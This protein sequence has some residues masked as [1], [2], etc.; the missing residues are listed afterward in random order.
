MSRSSQS[1][2]AT[3]IC[4]CNFAGSNPSG[5]HIRQVGAV[6]GFRIQPMSA[7]LAPPSSQAWSTLWTS[8]NFAPSSPPFH[9]PTYSS[10]TPS[11]G[12]PGHL[13]AGLFDSRV[14][15]NML[16]AHENQKQAQ[17]ICFSTVWDLDC[18]PP[19]HNAIH[20]CHYKPHVSHCSF[21]KFAGVVL[22]HFSDFPNTQNCLG[23]SPYA[24]LRLLNLSW[25]S[26]R[27]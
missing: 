16:Y 11:S 13:C 9:P 17:G 10:P 7:T 12:L 6:Y 3:R 2:R 1:D 14:A 18:A 15:I 27:Q 8:P 20:F 19:F 4:A 5:T 26:P 22:L 21:I 25:K 23:S 24:L